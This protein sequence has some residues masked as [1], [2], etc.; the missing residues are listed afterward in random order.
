MVG[1]GPRE[2]FSSGRPAEQGALRGARSMALRSRPEL[3]SRVRHLT[4]CDPQ[5]S[6]ERLFWFFRQK[7]VEV[8]LWNSGGREH[9][10]SMR[11]KQQLAGKL[12]G[13]T[14]TL[15]VKTPCASERERVCW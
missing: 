14:E 1:E 5:A 9:L 2:R 8:K 3:K 15:S 4:H 11:V 13:V 7:K 12:W 6:L 10:R